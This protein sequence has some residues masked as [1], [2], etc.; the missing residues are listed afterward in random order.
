MFET[1]LYVWSHFRSIY[2]EM[3]NIFNGLINFLVALK[4]FLVNLEHAPDA[5]RVSRIGGKCAK[6]KIIIH[7][8]F[9][10]S[11]FHRVMSS[12]NLRARLSSLPPALFPVGTVNKYYR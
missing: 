2:A 10:I 9:L 3:Q 7:I 4:L 5:A 6:K 12:V 1:V 11:L 8:S